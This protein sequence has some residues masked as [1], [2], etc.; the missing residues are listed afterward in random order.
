MK[1]SVCWMA[2][3]VLGMVLVSPR[4]TP[5]QEKTDTGPAAPAPQQVTADYPTNR[6]GVLIQAADWTPIPGAMPSKTR[7]KRGLAASLSYGAVPAA[8]AADYDGPHAQVQVEPGRPVICICRLISLPGAPAIVRLHPKK[9]RRELDGGKMTVLPIVGGSKTADAN[10]S[11]LIPV[12]VSQPEEMV[13][14]VR[15]Q[16]ALPAGEYALMLGTRNIYIFP[17]TVAPASVDSTAPSAG[18]H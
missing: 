8:I 4:L 9:D 6:P 16:Q 10:Q 1:S 11:D 18:K 13:W 7:V 3:S 2:F 15:P 12:D 14:L 5:G 17:F